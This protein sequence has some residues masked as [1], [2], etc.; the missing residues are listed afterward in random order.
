M[1]TDRIGPFRVQLRIDGEPKGQPRV[2]AFSR[3]GRARMYDPGTAE[4]WKGA[5]ALA[6]KDKIPEVP[7]S[8]PVRVVLH[9]YMPRPKSH[10]GTGKNKD[11]LKLNAPRAHTSKPDIDNLLKA[12]FDALSMIGLWRDDDQVCETLAFKEYGDR[13]GASILIEEIV[14]S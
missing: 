8:G 1:T 14:E 4:G 12:A 10:Y 2:R 9:H 7:L 3:G 11:S 6:F 13:P 5:I